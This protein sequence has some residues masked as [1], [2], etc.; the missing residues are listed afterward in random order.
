MHIYAGCNFAQLTA[1]AYRA[2]YF[3]FA[4]LQV[5]HDFLKNE[6]SFCSYT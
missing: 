5:L 3:N 4:A 6:N 1:S 2:M